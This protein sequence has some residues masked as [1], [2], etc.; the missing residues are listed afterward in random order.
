[1]ANEQYGFYVDT[2]RCIECWGCTVACKQ[3]NRIDAG[4]I[5]R[6]SVEESTEGTFPNVKRTFTS[7][8]CMHCE[9]PGCMAFCPVGAL[10]K[11]EE[12]G[13]VVVDRDICNGCMT[14]ENGCPFDVPKFRTI[15]GYEGI[16]MDKCDTCLSLGRQAGEDPHCVATCPLKALH[17]GTMT[18]LATLA[19]KKGG[20]LMEGMTGPSVYLS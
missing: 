7:L 2:T 4:T 6:R 15:E 20:K 9:N 14:C 11:R 1:M 19:A 8:S 5:A 17:F 12:D 10:S 16:K 13:V 18:E 3:W